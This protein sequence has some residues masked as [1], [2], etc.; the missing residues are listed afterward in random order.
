MAIA[1]EG[2]R[3]MIRDLQKVGVEVEDLKEVFGSIAAKAAD[4][5][6]GYV[7][8]KSGAL[9]ASVRGNRAKGKAVVTAGRARVQYAGA[10][11]YGW[12]RRN[13]RGQMFLQKADKVMETTAPEMFEEGISKIL[14]EMG[15]TE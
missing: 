9:A 5:A 4:V 1:V 13:I 6:S 10:I 7:K 11:N 12:P 2:L 3:E 14:Q 15:F 8:S